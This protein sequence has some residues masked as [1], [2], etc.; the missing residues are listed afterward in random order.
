MLDLKPYF[1]AVNSAEADVQRVANE[2]DTLFRAGTDE[3]KVA[4]LEMRS[5]LEAAQAKHAEAMSLYEAMQKANR[6]N[7]IA[8]NFV[9]VSS[10]TSE[11][12]EDNQPTV[13][14]RQEYERM[15]L[16]DR[17]RYIHSG[18]TLED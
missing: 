4:A 3:S 14:K 12:T 9:P 17:A 1:D 7:D 18:G 5:D 8:K 11:Q 15:S 13:I 10:A 6:P 2:I 16:T